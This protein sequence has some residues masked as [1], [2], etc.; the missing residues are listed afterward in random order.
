MRD[1]KRVLNVL[2]QVMLHVLQ[3]LFLQN[4]FQFSNLFIYFAIFFIFFL[5]TFILYFFLV[6]SLLVRIAISH[7]FHNISQYQ[8]NIRYVLIE[9]M[10]AY[11]VN[12]IQWQIK[13]VLAIWI[14]NFILFFYEF[15]WFG[16]LNFLF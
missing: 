8:Q 9:K 7:I 15:N 6:K 4:N 16:Y 2:I 11:N 14:K 5:I 1:S 10:H 13:L 3:Y 12:I